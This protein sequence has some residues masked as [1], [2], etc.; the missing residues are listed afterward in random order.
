M[1]KKV[2][3]ISLLSFTLIGFTGCSVGM[4]MSGKKEANVS[5]LQ[6]GDN[7]NMV[8]AKIGYQPVRVSNNG[9]KQIEIYEI[10]I[11]NEPSLGRAAGHG[12][13]DVLTLGAWELIGTPIEGL[14]GD[15]YELVCEYENGKLVNFYQN[16]KS[17]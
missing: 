13:M 4:A 8:A 3:C 14:S 7:R 1:F 15:K 17:K 10:E 9:N 2:L 12:V 16:K 6:I 11:G 5:S